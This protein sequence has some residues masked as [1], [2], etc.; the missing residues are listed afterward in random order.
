M[1]RGQGSNLRRGK[2][3]PCLSRAAHY[4]SG[5]P[6]GHFPHS[7]E[8]TR[9]V[10]PRSLTTR[11]LCRPPP[12]PSRTPTQ[13]KREDSNLRG[14]ITRLPFSRRTPSRTRSRFHDLSVC[15]QYV[16][17]VGRTRSLCG[18]PGVRTRDPP[19]K[20]R[21]LLP[22]E[23]AA[24][25]ESSGNRTRITCLEGRRSAIELPTRWWSVRD[26]NPN[27]QPAPPAP[28]RWRHPAL[29]AGCQRVERKSNPRRRGHIPMLCR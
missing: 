20:R 7:R 29:P 4:H 13:R 10:E 25:R 22:A 26:S 28:H 2:P 27:S 18:P 15:T 3:G 23:L 21:M 16:P 24:L 8:S 14:L 12:E 5:T 9:G 17:P 11:R 19:L 1:R 6:P